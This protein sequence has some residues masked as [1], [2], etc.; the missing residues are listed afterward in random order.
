MNIYAIEHVQLAMP[1]GG[2]ERAR[3]FYNHV[4]GLPEV[5]KPVNLAKRGGVWFQQGPVKVHLGVEQAFRPALKAHPAFLVEGLARLI[6]RCQQ[7]GYPVT[8]DE[9]LADFQRVYVA[10][11]FGNRIELMEHL[12]VEVNAE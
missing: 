4:L 12:P 11:P 2:E 3:H 5:P 10:D 7:A 1:P 8:S 9:P 6:E